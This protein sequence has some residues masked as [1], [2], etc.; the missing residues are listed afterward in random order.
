MRACIEMQLILLFSEQKN[1]YFI[2]SHSNAEY[3]P[4]I[5][6]LLQ[7]PPFPS[8]DIPTPFFSFLHD[9]TD[10]LDDSHQVRPGFPFKVTHI[11]LMVV[12]VFPINL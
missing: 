8:S 10:L 6:L 2:Q 3:T 11:L 4:I 1:F 9:I 12:I 7:T 5:D